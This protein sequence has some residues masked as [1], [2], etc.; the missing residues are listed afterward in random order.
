MKISI[1]V[2]I[3]NGEKTIDRCVQSILSQSYKDIEVILIND[4]SLDNTF[5]IINQYSDSRIKILNNK[6]QGAMLSRIAGI[7]IASGKYIMF[8]DADDWIDEKM[9][10]C[11]VDRT[12]NGKIDFIMC[13]FYGVS[14]EERKLMGNTN[15]R[16]GIVDLFLNQSINGPCCKL[17]KKEL[18]DLINIDNNFKLTLMEDLIINLKILEKVNSLEVINQGLYHYEYNVNSATHRYIDDK[19]MMTN[20]VYKKIEKFYELIEDESILSNIKWIYFRNLYSA[21]IDLHSKQSHKDFFEKIEK[22]NTYLK[23][24]DTINYLQVINGRYLSYPKR[25]L[26]LILKIKNPYLLYIMTYFMF[27]LKYSLRLR[28][29]R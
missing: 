25:L 28:I 19:F 1:I 23:N 16:K 7:H 6:N 2:P 24:K 22:I 4:G 12:D 15:I 14:L 3:Y 27:Y 18:F 17:M 29:S 11:L 26:L 5:E 20:Y 21:I 9:V 8:V 10:A 13:A